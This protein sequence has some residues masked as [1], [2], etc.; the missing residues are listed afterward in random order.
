[1]K[2]WPTKTLQN[3]YIK[4]RI[5]EDES[6]NKRKETICSAKG[7]ITWEKN[8]ILQTQLKTLMQRS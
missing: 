3:K 2:L 5:N 4:V 1:M 6:Y 8:T 7:K